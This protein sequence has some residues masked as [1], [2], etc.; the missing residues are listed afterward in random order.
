MDYDNWPKTALVY[1]FMMLFIGIAAA[2]VLY[3]ALSFLSAMIPI[4]T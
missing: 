3:L 1:A 4:E 2:A